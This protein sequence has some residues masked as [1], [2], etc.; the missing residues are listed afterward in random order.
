[1]K[2]FKGQREIILTK[3]IEYIQVYMSGILSALHMYV[4]PAFSGLQVTGDQCPSS[5]PR[6][7]SMH[8]ALSQKPASLTDQHT[9]IIAV[10]IKPFYGKHAADFNLKVSSETL[11]E[12]NL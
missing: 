1:M 10:A 4:S 5:M 7:S 11:G 6:F 9:N 2:F 3:N 8:I 12:A